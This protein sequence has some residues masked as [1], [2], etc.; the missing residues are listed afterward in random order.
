MT[1]GS[2]LREHRKRFPPDVDVERLAAISK[3]LTS[4]R[5]LSFYGREDFIPEREY[6][7]EQAMEAL[8]DATWVMSVATDL[9]GGN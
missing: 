7:R 5:E 2:I 1:W 4:E 9:I 6:T 3:L 8:N